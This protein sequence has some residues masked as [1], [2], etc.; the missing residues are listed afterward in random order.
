MTVR[1]AVMLMFRPTV[2]P[3]EVPGT[4]G[5]ELQLVA[6]LQLPRAST[7]QLPLAAFADPAMRVM[8]A[9]ASPAADGMDKRATEY[10]FTILNNE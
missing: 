4:L 2:S 7:F 8:A 6:A 3:A 5:L 1:A 10:G 9:R